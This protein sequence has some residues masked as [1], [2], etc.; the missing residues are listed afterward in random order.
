LKLGTTCLI[1]C[2]LVLTLVLTMVG[3]T[4]SDQGKLSQV[5]VFFDHPSQLRDLQAAGFDMAHPR[6]DQVDLFISPRDISQ[7]QDIGLRFQVIHDDVTRFYKSRLSTVDE[8]GGYKTLSEIRVY[9]DAM[10]A[11]HP[12]ILTPRISIGTTIEGRDIWAVKMS[13]NPG[14]DEDEPELLFTAGIHAREVI[15]PEVLFHFMDYLTD[16]YATDP[17][18]I[19]IVDNREIWFV[20]AVNPDGYYYNQVIAPDGGGMWRKNRRDNLD[21]TFGVDLNRNFGHMWAYDNI[22]S[23]PVTGRET[24][25]GTAPFSE[26]EAQTMRDFIIS[27]DFS[28]IVYYHSYSNLILWP[29]WYDYLVTDDNHVFQLLGDSIASYNGYEPSPAWDM[30]L[31]NGVS[32]D[33]AYAEQTL[34]NK[35]F[36]FCIEVGS[37]ADGFWPKLTRIHEL[38]SENLGVNLFLC[39]VADN[40]YSL[41]EP[42]R[43]ELTVPDTVTN[44][45]YVVQWIHPDTLNPAVSYELLELQDR[46]RITDSA[47]NFDRWVNHEFE[48]SQSEYHSDPPSFYSGSGAPSPLRYFQTEE[49]V[50]VDEDE[51]LTFWTSYQLEE[52]YTYAYVEV[53]TDGSLFSPIEGN[54]S[55]KRNP[56]GY[57]R[58]YGITGES[59]GWVEGRFGLSDFAGQ[60]LFVRFSFYPADSSD[61]QSA[62]YFDDIH[63]IDTF[64]VANSISDIAVTSYEFVQ[65]PVGDYYYRVRAMDEQNQWSPYSLAKRTYVQLYVCH[66]SDN[67]GYGD[68]EYPDNT[69]PDDNCPYDYNPDQLDSDGDGIGDACDNCCI[70][71]GDYNHNG[72]LDILDVDDFC[73]WALR[74][75]PGAQPPVCDLEVDVTGPEFGVPDGW[76]NILDIDY[77]LQYYLGFG[78]PLPECP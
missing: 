21:G 17:E 51:M 8:M 56:N 11:D 77:T 29:W 28:I 55:S 30:Y 42:Q 72:I 49:P 74:Q 38:V 32:L 76:I 44:Q 1:V 3:A 31:A 23:S 19:D 36:E 75:T 13:D 62:I 45:G 78:P 53:S 63:V 54:I 40:V 37:N 7:I 70:V 25:R 65:K 66:D 10:L 2:A 15:T 67:D 71:M 60:S 4:A 61:V 50:F 22:G 69:C 43:P 14:V 59:N 73:D 35:N 6:A 58:G 64:G 68:P 16:N 52:D 46:Y 48:L 5:T 26:P 24:Y 18:V 27:R 41:L 57:N 20:L 33:W 39:R 9:F 47:E 12:D 34:K